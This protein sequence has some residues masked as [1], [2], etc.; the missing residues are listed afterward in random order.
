MIY[1][2]YIIHIYIYIYKQTKV[3]PLRNNSKIKLNKNN[4]TIKLNKNSHIKESQ[5]PYLP[6]YFFHIYFFEYILEHHLYHEID[7][8]TTIPI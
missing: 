4:N 7:A 5:N 2:I 8:K 1:I 6:T 3:L